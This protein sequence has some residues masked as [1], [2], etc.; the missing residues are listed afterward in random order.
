MEKQPPLEYERFVYLIANGNPDSKR[1]IYVGLEYRIPHVIAAYEPEYI[2]T[3]CPDAWGRYLPE[4]QKRFFISYENHFNITKLTLAEYRAQIRAFRNVPFICA[5][6]F[7]HD[8]KCTHECVQPRI[9]ARFMMA[10]DAEYMVGGERPRLQYHHELRDQFTEGRSP[11]EHFMH[12]RP[13]HLLDD[14]RYGPFMHDPY[15]RIPTF[16]PETADVSDH[17]IPT[18]AAYPGKFT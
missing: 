5:D 10:D 11:Y 2:M 1:L 12:M 17:V 3:F 13:H 6:C 15:R 7:A 8:I 18:L 4:R 14:P 9:K 16:L